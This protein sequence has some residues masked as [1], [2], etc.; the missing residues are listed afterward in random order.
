MEDVFPLGRLWSSHRFALSAFGF[1][2]AGFE[3]EAVIT[4]FED[5]AMMGQPV[6]EC[7]RHLGIA[8]DACP[9]AEAQVGCDDDAGALVE[10]GQQMEQQGPA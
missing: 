3:A 4:G 2:G 9:F 7:G 10:L 6:E 1:S 5:V 8:E